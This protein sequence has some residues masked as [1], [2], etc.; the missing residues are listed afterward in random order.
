[1]GI[2]GDGLDRAAEQTFTRPVPKTAGAQ[3]RFLVKTEK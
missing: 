1:M 3:M 2:I